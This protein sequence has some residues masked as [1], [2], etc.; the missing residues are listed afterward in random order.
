MADADFAQPVEPGAGQQGGLDHP[1]VQFAQPGVDIAA[2]RY[3]AQI[4]PA[5]Q[6]QGGAAQTGGADQCAFGQFVER[7]RAVAD[8]RVAWIAAL[9]EAAQHQALGQARRHVLHAVHG[10]VDGPGQ[11]RLFDFLGEQALAAGLGQSA[12]LDAIAGGAH[13]HDFDGGLVG[14]SGMSPRQATAHDVRLDQRQRTC[15][16]ADAQ[17]GHGSV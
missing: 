11:Q 5:M 13:R 2:Q 4:G 1:I 15:A 14:Q 6:H 8:Q 10:Q 17:D 9:E 3:Y 7:A 12:V 16:G